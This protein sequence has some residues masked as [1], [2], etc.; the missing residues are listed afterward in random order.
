LYEYLILRN[1]ADHGLR[2]R[3]SA[4]QGAPSDPGVETKQY[5]YFIDVTIRIFEQKEVL[6]RSVTDLFEAQLR[7]LF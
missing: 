5:Q 2:G 3:T 6:K 4:H 1:T 7:K